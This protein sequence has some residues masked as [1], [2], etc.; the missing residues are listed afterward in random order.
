MAKPDSEKM[1]DKLVRATAAMT[2]QDVI[3]AVRRLTARE[4]IDLLEAIAVVLFHQKQA[5]R[6]S[7]RDT[8]KKGRH[9]VH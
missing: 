6:M 2:E 7:K 4:T 1:V 8:N 9:A 3:T 5:R